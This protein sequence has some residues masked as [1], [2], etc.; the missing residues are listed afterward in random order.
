MADVITLE[1]AKRTELGTT[2]CR[3][4]RRSGKV[5]ANVYGHEIDP[6]AVTLDA[7]ALRPVITSGT[8][9][10]DLNID[11]ATEK[12]LIRDV[13]WDTFS[14]DVQHLDLLRVDP[15]ERVEVEVPIH[16]RGTAPGVLANG[17]L[18]QMMHTLNVECPAVE[19]P[20]EMEVRINELQI[21][22][23]IHVRDLQDVPPKLTIL[24]EPD[25][26][27]VQVTEAVVELPEE[28]EEGV[29]EGAV[30]PEVIGRE[31]EEAGAESE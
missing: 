3:R 9:V 7:N 12:A 26:V 28:E 23:A 4:L 13:Q 11:G 27:I 22:D 15:N 1:A 19:I 29:V 31:E 8:H 21:G 14:M 25:A 16:L 30:E 17:M 5:P 2:A 24:D 10:V 6:V 18:E 20:D